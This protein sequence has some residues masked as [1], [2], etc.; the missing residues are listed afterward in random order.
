MMVAD[1]IA[2]KAAHLAVRGLV[3]IKA[4][5]AP[6]FPSVT[7]VTMRTIPVGVLA[8]ALGPGLRGLAILFAVACAAASAIIRKQ[9]PVSPRLTDWDVAVAACFGGAILDRVFS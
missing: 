8:A 5:P 7:L 4:A 3:Q 1:A 6:G 9:S 2:A